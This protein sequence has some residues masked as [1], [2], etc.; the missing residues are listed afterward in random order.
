MPSPAPAPIPAP[1]PSKAPGYTPPSGSAEP[2]YDCYA[3]QDIRD[4]CAAF[5]AA[6]GTATA[7][8]PLWQVYFDQCM[9]QQC[10]Q[11]V[12]TA[13]A[14]TREIIE[15]ALRRKAFAQSARTGIQ[16]VRPP[17]P[18]YPS[19]PQQ[20]RPPRPSHYRRGY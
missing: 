2:H 13:G 16:Q 7:S 20:T 4:Q 1:A 12:S 3:D 18:A 19:A 14:R 17:R 6:F 11:G 5:A 9:A 15:R 8:E 10:E